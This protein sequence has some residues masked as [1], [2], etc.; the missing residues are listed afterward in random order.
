MTEK[1]LDMMR[2]E[3]TFGRPIFLEAD[4]LDVKNW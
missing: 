4:P 3:T 1:I 2:N